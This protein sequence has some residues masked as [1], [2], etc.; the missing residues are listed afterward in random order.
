MTNKWYTHTHKLK[1]VYEQEEITVLW[2]QKGHTDREVTANRPDIMIKNK[3]E[4]TFI[5]TDVAT[6]T[7]R[8]VAQKEVEQKL[9]YKSLCIEIQ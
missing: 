7:D 4:K 1:P 3:K 6:P 9:K 2:S 5:L 8:N